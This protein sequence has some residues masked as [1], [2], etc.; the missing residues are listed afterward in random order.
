M[1]NEH[2]RIPGFIDHLRRRWPD[3]SVL[4]WYPLL[5]AARHDAMKQLIAA[6][7]HDAV[8]HEYEWASPEAKS[9]MYGSGMIGLNLPDVL[10]GFSAL[11][12]VC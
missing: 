11:Q 9:G 5:A 10:P 12:R 7:H 6:S 8:L 3:G 1:K 2:I 4:L